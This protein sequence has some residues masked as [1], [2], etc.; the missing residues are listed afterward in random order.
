MAYALKGVA[1]AES[2]P[3][4]GVI[5][6][7]GDWTYDEFAHGAGVTSL[8]VEAAPPPTPPTEEEKKSILDLFK[9]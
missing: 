7:G 1:P 4:E 5:N 2:R 6:V 9:N 8:G 3:P